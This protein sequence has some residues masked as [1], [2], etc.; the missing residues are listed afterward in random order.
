MFRGKNREYSEDQKI[1]MNTTDI[2]SFYVLK[3]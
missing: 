2:E 1:L 3:H